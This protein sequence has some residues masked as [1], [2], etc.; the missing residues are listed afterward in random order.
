MSR[1][2]WTPLVAMLVAC[3]AGRGRSAHPRE[4]DGEGAFGYLRQQMEFGP[5]IPGT[6][7]PREW[8]C[9]SVWPMP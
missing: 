7:A 6:P 3:P 9:C 8:R 4:F 5:R 1:T 2:L